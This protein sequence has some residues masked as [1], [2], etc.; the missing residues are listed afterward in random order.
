MKILF[1]FVFAFSLFGGGPAGPVAGFVLDS[2]TATIRA[3][4]G[5]PGATRLADPLALPFPIL[6]A[7]FAPS[8]DAAVV[9]TGDQPRHL[10]ILGSLLSGSPSIAD[11]GE[12]ADGTRLLGL[13]AK[14]TAAIVYSPAEG[15]LRFVIGIGKDAVLSAPVPAA[16]LAGPVTAGVLDEAGSCAILGTGSLETLCSDGSSRRVLTDSTFHITALA[17]TGN[18]R[19]LWVADDAGKQ[20]LRVADYANSSSAT[21][22]A[23]EADGLRKPVALAF[24]AAGQVLVAD[25]D[26]PAIFAIDPAAGTV[27]SI[28]LDVAPSQLRALTDRSL[29]LI[30]DLNALPFTL[31]ATEAMRTYFVPAN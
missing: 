30:N 14:G 28:A 5:I 11:L 1:G 22:F 4:T 20:I 2:R 8:G 9:I 23:S 12:V 19:D 25:S 7:E 15:Q 21:V 6:A 29:L 26:A 18:G 3:M 13:N 24:T 16:A 10:I 31:F 17:L 27:R